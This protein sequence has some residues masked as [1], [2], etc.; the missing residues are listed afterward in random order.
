MKNSEKIKQFRL[1]YK[2]EK[3]KVFSRKK[4]TSLYIG[5]L[6]PTI[7]EEDVLNSFS[8][9]SG[10]LSVIICRSLISKKS[11]GYGYINF[12]DKDYAKRAMKKMNFFLDKKLFNKPLRLMWKE[13]DKSRRVSG[14]GN[15]FV[16]YL[17]IDFKTIDLYKLFTSFGK[18]LSCKISFNENGCSKKFGFVH[19]FS[20]RDAMEAIKK[21]N[22]CNIQGKLLYVSPYIKKETRDLFFPKNLN[23]TNVYIK[24]LINEKFTETNIRNMFEV[25]GEITSIMIPKENNKPRGFAFVNFGSHLDAEDAIFKMNNKKVGNSIIY[26]SRAETKLER[27][28]TLNNARNYK[29]KWVKVIHQKIFLVVSGIQTE[30][31]LN[32]IIYLLIAIGNLCKYKI[33]QST[34]NRF[35]FFTNVSSRKGGNF[36]ILGEKKYQNIL[37]RYFLM[38]FSVLLKKKHN[39][40]VGAF[41]KDIQY[42]TEQRKFD[43]KFWN[44][45]RCLRFKNTKINTLLIN[46]M[47]MKYSKKDL[48]YGWKK[49][50]HF[51]FKSKKTDIH[52]ELF[53]LLRSLFKKSIEKLISFEKLVKFESEIS[54]KIW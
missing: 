21:L 18:I 7:E 20:S 10:L 45:K 41:S 51:W 43:I 47:E 48:N 42:F 16:N 26:V 27:K 40:F 13:K 9:M 15:I 4:N 36:I 3:L 30:I 12:K 1:N 14:K 28:S 31:F 17:P 29:E 24:N 39:R 23:F 52:P 54:A 50:I 38:F 53:S 34:S 33:I 19:F 8:K 22:G 44:N 49:I 37:I 46:K 11:L 25:F 2:T 35:S 32:L 5:D 6:S